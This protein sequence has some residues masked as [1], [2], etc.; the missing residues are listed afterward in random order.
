MTTILAFHLLSFQ[1]LEKVTENLYS[2]KLRSHCQLS[3]LYMSSC[4]ELQELSVS[5][6]EG[7]SS[8]MGRIP[9]KMLGRDTDSQMFR[10]LE[11]A[12]RPENSNT[13]KL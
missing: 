2:T 13:L 9:L 1:I 10:E 7:C 11:V 6:A 12:E 8:M 5:A 4:S 3:G